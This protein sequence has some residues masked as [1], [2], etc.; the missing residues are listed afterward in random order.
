MAEN[1]ADLSGAL[2][3]SFQTPGGETS[4]RLQFEK[5]FVIKDAVPAFGNKECVCSTARSLFLMI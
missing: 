5:R 1:A 2:R 4:G 3:V